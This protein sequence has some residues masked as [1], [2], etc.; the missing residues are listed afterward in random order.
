LSQDQQGLL[1][2]AAAAAG[3]GGGGVNLP[4]QA[5]QDEETHLTRI[6]HLMRIREVVPPSK[7]AERA[8]NG[9]ISISN[10][11]M[12]LI[13]ERF[14]DAETIKC[15]L[16]LLP[17]IGPPNRKDEGNEDK[18]SDHDSTSIDVADENNSTKDEGKEEELSDHDSTS[19]HFADENNSA[20]KNDTGS[21]SPKK[22]KRKTA[23]SGSKARASDKEARGRNAGKKAKDDVAFKK[24]QGGVGTGKKQ[25]VIKPPKKDSVEEEDTEEKDIVE[26]VLGIFVADEAIM[27][28]IK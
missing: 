12:D 6:R 3:G 21:N 5:N 9:C 7:M 11:E 4:L 13:Y 15:A 28:N 18:L 24:V 10:H 23:T 2:A 22:K 1:A 8:R 19:I 16:S 27:F 17:W 26:K 20:P 25:P 14:H